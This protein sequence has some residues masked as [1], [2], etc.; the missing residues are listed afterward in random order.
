[1]NFLAKLPQ[2]HSLSQT[3]GGEQGPSV[4]K[5][6]WAPLTWT[7]AGQLRLPAPNSGAFEGTYMELEDAGERGLKSRV[8]SL[9]GATSPAPTWTTSLHTG[10]EEQKF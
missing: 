3:R 2:M 6:G 8:L 9:S 5:P 7:R 10:L 1:M 4:L